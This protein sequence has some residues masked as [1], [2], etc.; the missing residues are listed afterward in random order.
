[1][2]IHSAPSSS[3]IWIVWWADQTLFATNLLSPPI[4]NI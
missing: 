1:M 2:E 3:M 4:A